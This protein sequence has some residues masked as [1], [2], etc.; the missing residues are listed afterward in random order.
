MLNPE[1]I[2]AT[3]IECKSFQVYLCQECLTSL[4][5]NRLPRLA[6]NNNLF[7]GELPDDLKD[8][9]WVE[10]MAVALYRTTAFVS[11]IYGTSNA[12]DPL[13]LHGNVCAH[14][15]D[16]VANTKKLPWTPADLNDLIS[17]VFVGR[18]RLTKEQLNKL[19][20][21]F[22]RQSVI[23]RLLNYLCRHHIQYLGIPPPDELSLSLY[24]ENG[25]L[26]GLAD[27]IVYDHESDPI[28]VFE[29]ESKGFDEH[30]AELLHGN[31]KELLM[32]RSR[33]LRSRS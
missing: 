24:P 27:R 4:S 11:R 29:S 19:T 23:R 14:P 18:Q 20:Q 33:R 9:T 2:Q 10:E 12:G 1:G 17:I 5:K 21:Y 13:Q 30:P 3:D 25:L 32:E 26:P 31:Q 15:L 6:L 22:V 16:F 8:V 7:R 28:E